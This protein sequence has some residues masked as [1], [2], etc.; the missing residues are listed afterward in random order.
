[1]YERGGKVKLVVERMLHW[2][3]REICNRWTS[4]RCIDPINAM[5]A[6]IWDQ[7]L[8]L[9]LEEREK[10]GAR[11]REREKKLLA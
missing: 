8:E 11:E 3:S 5:A 6:F 10:A 9:F 4:R 1:M 2:M 7:N